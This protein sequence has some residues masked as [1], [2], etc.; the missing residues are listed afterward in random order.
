MAKAYKNSNKKP[1]A[2]INNKEEIIDAIGDLMVYCLGL[3]SMI[4]V[5]GEEV[6]SKIIESNEKRIHTG[7]M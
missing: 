2:E 5:S 3:C 4:G 6:L 1:A 7:H